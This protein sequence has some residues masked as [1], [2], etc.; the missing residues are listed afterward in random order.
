M[1]SITPCIQNT[2]IQTLEQECIPVGYIPSAAVAVC[3]VGGGL[4]Q[5]MFGYTPPGVGLETPLG[6]GLETPPTRPLNLPPK[7]GPG[8]P[9]QPD[10]STSSL[11]VG[12]ETTSPLPSQ[13]PQPPFGCGPGDPPPPLVDRQARVKT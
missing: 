10:P 7:C 8:D 12:L 2:E 1:N 4:P 3:L 13:T 9:P 5:C 6:V 11:G